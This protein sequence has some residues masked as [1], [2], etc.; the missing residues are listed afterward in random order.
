[1]LLA[2]GGT[3]KQKNSSIN[4]GFGIDLDLTLTPYESAIVKAITLG[5]NHPKGI[6]G[7]LFSVDRFAQI[8]AVTV[9]AKLKAILLL[10]RSRGLEVIAAKQKT[11]NV[12]ALRGKRIAVPY[13][14]PARF[15]FLWELAQVPLFPSDYQLVSVSSSKD[16]AKLFTES[17]VDAAAG[18]SFDLTE[19]ANR[20]GGR[21]VATSAD[22]PQLCAMVLVMR[23]EFLVRFPDAVRRL[24]RSITRS[25]QIIRHNP[26]EGTRML[27]SYA[28][29]LGDPYEALKADP[30]ATHEEN[31]AFFDLRGD[32]PVHYDE[33]F[34]S[35]VSLW[36]KM[37]EPADTSLPAASRETS[38]LL[39]AP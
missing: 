21:I 31:L 3:G 25:A 10:S 26:T 5:G 28:P 33:L 23:S 13:R 7:A 22:A 20:L 2:A 38:F 12:A 34:S 35:A 16:A 4:K 36:N 32:S 27:A 9:N 37:E 39:S 18:L 8:R 30:P 17:K 15:F 6:D 1:L 24:V 11:L 14:S 29:E 19:H